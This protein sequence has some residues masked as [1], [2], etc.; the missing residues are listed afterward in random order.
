LPDSRA[1]QRSRG[2]HSSS[3][4]LAAW[5][6]ARVANAEPLPCRI[7]PRWLTHS[8]HRLLSL[9][10]M[11]R[12]H[13][14]LVVSAG[15][16]LSPSIARRMLAACRAIGCAHWHAPTPML[17]GPPGD[18][19]EHVVYSSSQHSTSPGV[20]T[21]QITR[22]AGPASDISVASGWDCNRCSSSGCPG[23]LAT[24]TFTKLPTACGQMARARPEGRLHSTPS[25]CARV[26]HRQGG[27]G[28]AGDQLLSSNE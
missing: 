22:P 27:F 14:S 17:W 9:R 1:R 21:V 8:C 7:L 13:W 10:M 5:L 3:L 18:S 12:S 15:A 16:A 11:R 4:R 20:E 2:C 19:S 23:R 6:I 26:R 24:R 25:R 28:L